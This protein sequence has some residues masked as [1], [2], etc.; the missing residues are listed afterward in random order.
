M[1]LTRINDAMRM[2]KEAR[3]SAIFL[4]FTTLFLMAVFFLQ[5]TAMANPSPEEE[6]QALE[7]ELKKLEQQISQYEQDVSKTQQEKQTLKNR[8]AYL[9][10]QVEKLNLQITQGNLMIRDLRSQV[11]ATQKSMEV[12]ERQI[13]AYRERLTV[14][15]RRLYQESQKSTLEILLAEPKFSDFFAS[16]VAL[17]QLNEENQKLLSNIKDLKG[18]LET[19]KQAIEEEKEDLEKTVQIQML[20]K[21]QHVATQKEQQK[22]L[23]QTEGKEQ[24]YQQLLSVTRQRAAEIRAR[25][26]ELI[27]VAVAPTF[28]EAAEIAKFVQSVTGIRPAFLLAVLT[29]ESNIGKNVGQCYVTNFTTGSGVVAY[30]GKTVTRVMHP[31]R[32]IPL[33]LKITEAVGRDPSRTP[34]SCPL[35]DVK[36]YGGAMGPAQF[37]PS[38][39]VLIAQKVE[40]VTGKA[41]D[42]WNIKDAFL[43]A[44]I[45]LRDLGGLTSEFKAAMMY[46][47]GSSW[48]KYEEFYGRSVLSIAERYE[49]DLK[50][51]GE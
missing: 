23:E 25:I 4:L 19:Q 20:Q 44:G 22:I 8:I 46:F 14:I 51:I 9:K 11:Q 35:P 10:R 12:T 6:R 29:Q 2:K 18:Y 38:T 16:V 49:Q 24:M 26:F 5:D 15:L 43:A 32:D 34:V 37:I 21:Q 1:A 45:Y 48:T 40:A 36:G 28:G 39:W 47:S 41:A 7:E 30:N 31:T 50:E 27:G 17:E 3:R 42:P 33:F 13:E